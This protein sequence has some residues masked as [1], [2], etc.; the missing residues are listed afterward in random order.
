MRNLSTLAIIMSCLLTGCSALMPLDPAPKPKRHFNKEF[1]GAI[2]LSGWGGWMEIKLNQPE[3]GTGE[4]WVVAG[5]GKTY[6]REKP[7][8][9]IGFMV[10]GTVSVKEEDKV[11]LDLYVNSDVGVEKQTPDY[12]MEATYAYPNLFDFK[13]LDPT[14][15]SAKPLTSGKLP[16]YYPSNTLI[17]GA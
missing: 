2:D 9:S 5:I 14:D 6:L 3:N 17:G 11:K 7:Q 1:R 8:Y 15:P 4:G 16:V 10:Q 13:L 12:I